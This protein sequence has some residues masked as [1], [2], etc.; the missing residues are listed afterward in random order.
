MDYTQDP[1]VEVRRSR[2][3]TVYSAKVDVNAEDAANQLLQIF[4]TFGIPQ[5]Y[6]EC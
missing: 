6:C 1:P 4:K 3:K 2:P 5:F